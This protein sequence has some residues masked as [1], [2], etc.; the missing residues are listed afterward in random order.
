MHVQLVVELGLGLEHT[1][2]GGRSEHAGATPATTTSA[3]APAPPADTPAA[4]FDPFTDDGPVVQ[5]NTVTAAA[6]ATVTFQATQ[7]VEQDQ[8]GADP[9]ADL[10]AQVDQRLANAQTAIA[11]AVAEQTDPENQNAVRGVPVASV[12]QTNFVAADA[13]AT[14]TAQVI[15]LIGQQQETD[16]S[17]APWLVAGQAASNS[18]T[19]EAAA[20]AVQTAPQNLDFVVAPAPNQAAVGGVE[21]TNAGMAT[22]GT[23]LDTF[24]WQEIDQGQLVG[25]STEQE[26]DAAQAQANAQSGLVAATVAQTRTTNLNDLVVPAGSRATNPTVRQQNLAATGVTAT[27]TSELDALITQGQGGSGLAEL[28]SAAQQATVRQSALAYSPA[29]QSDLLNRAAWA[30]IEPP[31]DDS[32]APPP[33]APPDDP[34]PGSGGGGNGAPN[35]PAPVPFAPTAPFAFGTR[36]STTG[37]TTRHG[38]KSPAAAGPRS[39]RAPHRRTFVATGHGSPAALAPASPAPALAPFTPPLVP[40]EA[41]GATAAPATPAT[42]TRMVTHVTATSAASGASA[43]SAVASITTVA[44]SEST[45]HGGGNVPRDREHAGAGTGPTYPGCCPGNP[46]SF[47]ATGSAP[48]PGSAGIVGDRPGTFKLAAPAPIGP[49]MPTPTLGRSVAFLDP[50]ERPG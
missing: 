45:E 6:A 31:A 2:A 15:Q 33:D 49:R 12:T 18:Q 46:P 30:G 42:S 28:A 50:F 20:Q 13:T 17:V 14:A 40:R 9:D 27:D 48:P 26:A 8:V 4:A 5:T 29:S 11:D 34:G 22:A 25:D 1:G 24:V 47:G 21:Q 44:Q 37:T 43:P 32:P 3:D 16:Q 35:A 38:A 7:Q 41:P 23:E 39:A 36:A 10:G 19:A